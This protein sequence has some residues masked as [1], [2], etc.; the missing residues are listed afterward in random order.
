MADQ[1]EQ[2]T[3]G[4]KCK[5]KISY[6]DSDEL[7]DFVLSENTDNR[8]QKRAA[9]ATDDK[10]ESPN[11]RK[12]TKVGDP[13]QAKGKKK[14]SV[15]SRKKETNKRIKEN[16][17][18]TTKSLNSLKK[19]AFRSMTKRLRKIPIN[20]VA[21]FARQFINSELHVKEIEN[22]MNVV[23]MIEE[24]KEMENIVKNIYQKGIKFT[25]ES[26][27]TILKDR[28]A[29]YKIRFTFYV[30][31]MLSDSASNA[32][33]WFNSNKMNM[34]GDKD[35]FFCVIHAIAAGIF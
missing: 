17:K 26:L 35:Y 25:E 20:I 18:K 22:R 9:T 29:V 31:D 24:T 34:K 3:K 19:V 11:P 23:Q 12:K 15:Q 7:L 16:P 4:R 13:K 33:K 14:N 1:T 28:Q 32:M 10:Y 6:A 27:S 21:D 5:R 2:S 8:T 30:R